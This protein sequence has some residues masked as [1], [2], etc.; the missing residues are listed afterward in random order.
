M[1]QARNMNPP[2]AA[3]ALYNAKNKELDIS[4]EVDT[5]AMWAFFLAIA[6]LFFIAIP[7][8][9]WIMGFL[10]MLAAIP[11]GILGILRIAKD[12]E[13]R[14]GTGFAVAAII[15][16]VLAILAGLFVFIALAL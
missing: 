9:G 8:I 4:K 2:D 13:H 11:L 1:P 5:C 3:Q 6:P 10:C 15:I 12:H 16:A 7:V 14:K